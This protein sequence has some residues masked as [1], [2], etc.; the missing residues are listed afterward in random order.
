MWG[1]E[2]K[3]FNCAE[4]RELD[5]V[6]YLF[7][8]GHTPV[9]V[10]NNDY[11]YLSPLR[12]ETEASFKVNR[13][14][15]IIA[16]NSISNFSLCRYLHDRSI[17]LEIANFYCKEVSFKLN[18]KNYYAI[19][20]KNQAG[21]YELRNQFFKASSSPKDVTVIENNSAE[22]VAVFEGFF[23]FLSY[24]TIH[25]NQEQPLTNFLVLNSLSFFQRSASLLEKHK[26]IH[27]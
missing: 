16:V 2:N 9:K 18:D 20:F 17:P 13:K 24:Q 11:W 21:G 14:L 23:S 19:G 1:V 8:L 12:R 26:S 15:K 6:D 25:K 3:L 22:E 27:L 10:R 7:S 4:A 5:L